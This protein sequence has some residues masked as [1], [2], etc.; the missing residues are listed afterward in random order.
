MSGP[1]SSTSPPDG[2][3]YRLDSA[4]AVDRA[5]DEIAEAIMAAEAQIAAG[6]WVDLAGLDTGVAVLCDATLSLGDEGPPLL[7]RLLDLAAGLEGLSSALT[8]QQRLQQ[9]TSAAADQAERRQRA[10]EVYG[11]VPPP[12]IKS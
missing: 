2:F 7:P 6:E 10:A 11:R 4:E 5:I 3:D 12:Q 9:E 1:L 8:R